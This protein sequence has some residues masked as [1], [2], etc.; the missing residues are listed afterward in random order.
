MQNKVVTVLGGSGFVGRYVVSRLAQHGALIKVGCRNANQAMHL[1]PMGA[2]GQI[3]LIP[4]NVRDEESLRSIIHGSD[5]VINLVGILS[6]TG[7]QTFKGLHEKAAGVIAKIAKE[8]NV[9]KLIHLSSMGVKSTASSRYAVT[10]AKAEENI[11]LSFRQAT[12][13]R[14]SLIYGAEDNFFNKFAKLAMISPFLPLIGD[15]KTK[16]QPVYVGDVADA[17]IEVLRQ[18]FQGQTFELGGQEIYTFKQLMTMIK[19]V[20]NRD[21]CLVSIPFVFAY[22]IGA[23]CQLLPKP[24][25]TIDQVRLLKVD[26][27]LTYTKPGFQEL[28][29]QPKAVEAIIPSYLKRFHKG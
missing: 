25:L 7:K 8:A 15:G 14:S 4:T 24:L 1:L 17:I 18:N 28:G 22:I 13:I 21:S 29:I 11:Y 2:V 23:V 5:V 16:F 10:K 3:K 20:I 27:V 19:G 12:I 9:G 6:E 26:S